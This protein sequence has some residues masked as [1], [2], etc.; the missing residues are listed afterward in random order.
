MSFIK[1]ISLGCTGNKLS[2]QITGTEEV[3]AGR[4][5]VAVG[6]GMTLGGIATSGLVVAGVASAPIVVPLAIATGLVA[7]IASMFE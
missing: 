3:N 7:G 4:S 5:A 6:T 1:A 2:K